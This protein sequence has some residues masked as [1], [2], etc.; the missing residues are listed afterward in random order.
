[1]TIYFVIALGTLTVAL[2][3]A[4]VAYVNLRKRLLEKYDEIEVLSFENEEL[5]AENKRY[6]KVVERTA[7]RIREDWP[8]RK[9]AA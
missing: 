2:T 3:G 4:L 5:R 7:D 1:M 9:L 8:Q 6:K